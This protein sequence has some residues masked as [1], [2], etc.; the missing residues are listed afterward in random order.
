[1]QT[2]ENL[3]EQIAVVDGLGQELSEKSEFQ[4]LENY[5]FDHEQLLSAIV[6]LVEGQLNLV[7]CST[8]RLFLVSRMNALGSK[9]KRIGLED[10]A[11]LKLITDKQIGKLVVS[12]YSVNTELLIEGISSVKAQKFGKKLVT[13][14]QSWTLNL[15]NNN[16]KEK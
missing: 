6:C 9:V 11:D 12:F 13:A 10:I 2:G 3:Q 7:A 14:I 5:L 15:Q 16:L 1:M 4:V 8:S